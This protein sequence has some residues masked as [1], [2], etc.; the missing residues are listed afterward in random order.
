MA[1][2]KRGE[3]FD[4]DPAADAATAIIRQHHPDVFFVHL[5]GVDVVGHA[6]GWGTDKQIAAIEK[7]DA[8]VGRILATLKQEHVDDSTF[9]I[10]TADHGGTGKWHGPDDPRARHIPWIIAGPGIRQNLDLTTFRDLTVN[11]EDT[12]ATT[13]WLMGIAYSQPIDGKPLTVIARN[14]DL[15]LLHDAPA[16]AAGK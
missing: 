1:L 12:F 5:G 16:P 11:T 9:V 10:L 6:A 13:C 14:A 4:D 2:P 8:C 7:A 15:Q 3:M